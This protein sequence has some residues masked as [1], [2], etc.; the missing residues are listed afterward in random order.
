MQWGYRG[1]QA[2]FWK[3]AL[4]SGPIRASYLPFSPLR[5]FERRG[6]VAVDLQFGAHKVGVLATQIG[7]ARDGRIREWRYVRSALRRRA[8]TALLFAAVPPSRIGLTDL[9][10][11][12]VGCR[13]VDD[14]CI[15]VRGFDVEEAADDAAAHRGIGRAILARLRATET[16]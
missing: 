12:R 14:E 2:V 3:P 13:G 6:M 5:P 10:F 9:G 7:T 1:G 15:F 4:A 16:V 8:G 11:V